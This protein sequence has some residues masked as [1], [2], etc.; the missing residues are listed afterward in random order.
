ML[1]RRQRPI[2]TPFGV[3]QIRK[4]VAIERLAVDLIKTHDVFLKKLDTLIGIVPD[5]EELKRIIDRK[6]GPMGPMGPR[7]PKGDSVKGEPGLVGA[8]G[9]TPIKGID[10]MTDDDIE[11][12]AQKAA[13]LV[14]VKDGKDAQIDEE[15]VMGIIKK[16]KIHAKDVTG[17][18]QTT[19]AFY[20]QLIARGGYL[21]GGGGSSSSGTGYQ[22]ATGTVNGSNKNFSFTSAPNV[23]VVD[24]VPLQKTQKDGT[25]NW[26][27]G[28][29]ITLTVAPNYDIYASA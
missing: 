11:E 28:S 2:P 21:H 16:K 9:R 1:N 19:S 4:D 20:N 10:Y 3:D 17:L 23:V 8:P 18:E 14:K 7:G 29:T 26:T 6:I 13:K 25:V 5:V 22:S 24:G 27:G 12:L 15:K